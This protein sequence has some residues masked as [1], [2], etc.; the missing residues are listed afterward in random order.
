MEYDLGPTKQAA[1]EKFF[2]LLI[3][4]GEAE[5]AALPLKIFP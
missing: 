3:D 5:R 2:T 1:L 4:R